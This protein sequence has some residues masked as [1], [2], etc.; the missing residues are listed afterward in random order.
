V[1]KIVVTGGGALLHE[2][3]ECLATRLKKEV[4][5]GDSAVLLDLGNFPYKISSRDLQSYSTA[6]GLAL[7]GADYGN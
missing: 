2:L 1:E 6:I 3:P 5:M 7:R 4:V